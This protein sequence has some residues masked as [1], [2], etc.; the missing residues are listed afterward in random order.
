MRKAQKKKKKDWENEE[1]RDWKHSTDHPSKGLGRKLVS[2]ILGQGTERGIGRVERNVI[3]A[4]G[5]WSVK[6]S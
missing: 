2:G 4:A 1:D 3:G 6:Y 5:R